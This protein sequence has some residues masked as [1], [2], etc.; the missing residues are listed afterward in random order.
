MSKVIGM[1]RSVGEIFGFIFSSAEPKTF[2]AVVQEL[3]ISAGSASHGL[4]Y[5]RRIGVI[6]S[7][8]LARD[9]RD[10]FTAET[11]FH[12]LLKGF[13]GEAVMTH[14]VTSHDRL[15]KLKES[16]KAGDDANLETL[17]EKLEVLLEWHQQARKAMDLVMTELQ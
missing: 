2:D 4:R 16:V 8:Y 17:G 7:V 12:V 10:H 11:S 3:G 9:R 14:L 1:P 6:R 13:L 5:L 15:E